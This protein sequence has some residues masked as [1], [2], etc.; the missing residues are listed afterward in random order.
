MPTINLPYNFTPRKYQIPLLD[1]MDS[2]CRH[3]MIVWN[4]RSGK[5]KT[6]F[7]IM[8]KKAWERVGAYYYIMPTYKQGRDAIWEQMDK[9]SGF[10]MVG[11]VPAEILAGKNNVDMKLRLKN[12]SIIQIM[13]T[14]KTIENL[15]G[16]NP[17]GIVYSEF[18]LQRQDAWDVMRP[19]LT[20][21]K[22]WVIMNMTPKGKA[23]HSYKMWTLARS[24]KDWFTELL[25][26]EDTGV[27]TMEDYDAEIASG[28]APEL[29][30][31]EFFSDWL[32]T[33]LAQFIPYDVASMA[34]R[35]EYD[36]N[37]LRYSPTIMGV[38]VAR[39]GDDSSVI[40][41]RKGLKTLDYQ[42]YRH[43]DTMHIASMVMEMS[44]QYREDAIFVDV[45][46]VG[47]GVVDR[48]KQL[49][50]HPIEANGACRSVNNKRFYN[51]RAEMWQ[52]MK[53]WLMNGGSIPN[54]KDLIEQLIGIE[55]GFT[56]RDQQFMERKE[57]M[58]GRGMV[59]PDIADALA[60]TF[61]APVQGRTPE[62]DEDDEREKMMSRRSR[63]TSMTGY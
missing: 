49:G 29:A 23:H 5:D 35:R 53:E 42:T 26:I 39:Y 61:Y 46:G 62:D 27:M 34:A 30:R 52:N 2:G 8:V 48:L 51:K 63:I 43:M 56:S 22:G 13:G 4:R 7:N 57:D 58:K 25:T 28:M 18:S 32:A 21:N 20:E 45:V 40:Y 33:N 47:A 3:A 44:A 31:Q 16:T 6:C 12:G 15:R 59:S 14:D 38:D 50:K 11:H 17:L 55:Y 24:N 37:D 19:I 10:P 9:V 60:M 1:A 54:D 41:V 36:D